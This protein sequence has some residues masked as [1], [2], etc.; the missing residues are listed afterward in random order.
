MAT[1]LSKFTAKELA[2]AIGAEL[3]RGRPSKDTRAE[4]EQAVAEALA[5]G[6]IARKRGK[7]VA[8]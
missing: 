7:L 4:L 8:V 6:S 2:D 1:N 3:G 5:A